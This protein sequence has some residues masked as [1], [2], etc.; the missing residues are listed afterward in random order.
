MKTAYGLILWFLHRAGAAAVTMP[1][2]TIYCLP[3][4]EADA[5]LLAH[6][7]VHIEQI[8]RD[9]WFKWLLII[10]YDFEKYGYK[11]SPEEVEAR[12]RAGY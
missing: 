6:E 3:G 10:L 5:A 2:Q 9:G 1:W 11:D 12:Q 4:R 8:K 7:Q